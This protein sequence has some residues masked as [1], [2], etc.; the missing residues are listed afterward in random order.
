MRRENVKKTE[1]RVD[2]KGQEL[3]LV[4]LFSLPQMSSIFSS[5]LIVILALKWESRLLYIQSGI[6]AFLA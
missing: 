1:G 5:L 4:D 2:G 6:Y 3:R